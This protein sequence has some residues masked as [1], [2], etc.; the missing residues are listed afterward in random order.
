M[1][2]WSGEKLLAEVPARGIVDPYDPGK[3]DCSAY[4]LT[5]GHEFFVSPDYATPSRESVSRS[6]KA[7]SQINLGGS[8]R[9]VPG[10]E[11]VIPSG[12][13]ALLL[14]EEYVK[15][16][17]DAMGF[18]SLKFGVKGPG[19]I[20]VSGFHV[21][22]GYEGKLIFSVYNAG[23]KS[24]HLQR[25]QDVFLL[26]LADLDRPSSF[27]KSAPANPT[28]SI[29]LDMI[30]RADA[31]VHSIQQLSDRIETLGTQINLF[32]K[33]GALVVAIASVIGALTFFAPDEPKQP[34]PVPPVIISRGGTQPQPLPP[35]KPAPRETPG[36]KRS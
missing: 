28:M 2:F 6:L 20:N 4:T 25:G 26:W 35:A 30:S 13:F 17:Y 1:A 7:P 22:P 3:I 34:A 23:P 10:G 27:I 12:Q 11:L 18:I 29:P 19:L 16:P 24:A 5:L 33:L 15:I 9:N 8:L 36:E 21:D 14:T 31:P 32:K